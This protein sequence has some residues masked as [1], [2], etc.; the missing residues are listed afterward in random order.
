MILQSAFLLLI[1]SSISSASYG[2]VNSVDFSNQNITS[3]D[4]R[5]NDTSELTIIFAPYNKISRVDSS[6]F[7][8]IPNLDFLDLHANTIDS[9]N[10]NL[11]NLW[12]LNLD[13]ALRNFTGPSGGMELSIGAHPG[14]GVSAVMYLPN[15][16]ELHLCC[17]KITRING[18]TEETV[19]NLARLY[20]SFNDIEYLDFLDKLPKSITHLDLQR[21][22]ILKFVQI[23]MPVKL[24]GSY[25]VAETVIKKY[26]FNH[27][28]NLEHLDLSYN[29]IG[30]I[31]DHTFKNLSKLITLYLNNNE[32]TSVPDFSGLTQIKELDISHNYIGDISNATFDYL[33]SLENLKIF[34]DYGF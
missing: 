23:I 30:K 29:K 2:P 3:L 32:L 19:P 16:I 11:T 9:I 31:E 22:K 10:L 17:N 13:S 28:E 34:G 25:P 4:G 5:L 6:T 15:L 20:L 27:L 21:N 12:K 24:L 33:P 26:D 18:L 1:S 14:V 8:G 7:A